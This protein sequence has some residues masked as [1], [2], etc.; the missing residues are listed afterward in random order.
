MNELCQK[1]GLFL[2]PLGRGFQV[3]IFINKYT[4]ICYNVYVYL[5]LLYY[6]YYI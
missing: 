4:R 2:I 1:A 3:D 6:K 5:T